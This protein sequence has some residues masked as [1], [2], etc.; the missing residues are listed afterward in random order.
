MLQ[1]HNENTF[2]YP[3]YIHQKVWPAMRV[4]FYLMQRA[5]TEAF[6]AFGPEKGYYAGFFWYS[7]VTLVIFT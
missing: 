5:L 6:L 3:D 1:V 2:D 7:V 4:N